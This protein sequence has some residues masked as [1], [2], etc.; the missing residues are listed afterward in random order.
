[1]TRINEWSKLFTKF[2]VVSLSGSWCIVRTSIGKAR[3]LSQVKHIALVTKGTPSGA[4][5]WQEIIC[6]VSKFL[7][8]LI[9]AKGGAEPLL[10]FINTKCD[11]PTPNP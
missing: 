6:Q 11:L 8:D 9:G 5:E 7:G 2:G 1:M 10:D 4:S 3:R